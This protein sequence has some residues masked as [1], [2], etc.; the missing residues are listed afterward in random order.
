MHNTC[1]VDENCIALSIPF[2]CRD[3]KDERALVAVN[4]KCIRVLFGDGR[5]AR[6]Q[7][8]NVAG[9]LQVI[10][11]VVRKFTGTNLCT[12]KIRACMNTNTLTGFAWLRSHIVLTISAYDDTWYVVL[13]IPVIHSCV[14]EWTC[15]IQMRYQNMSV[16]P[17][18][19]N[20]ISE[21]NSS[22]FQRE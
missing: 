2:G 15:S 9:V 13:H 4:D 10:F 3:A 5:D 1:P 18:T 22:I 19:K 14:L 21:P 12:H 16:Y 7:R 8:D 20:E 17:H 6:P 11:L